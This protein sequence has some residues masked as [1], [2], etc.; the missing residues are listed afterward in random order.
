MHDDEAD[1]SQLCASRCELVASVVTVEQLPQHR[2]HEQLHW[3][4]PLEVEAVYLHHSLHNAVFVH[5]EAAL[6]GLHVLEEEAHAFHR[7]GLFFVV[8][9]EPRHQPGGEVGGSVRR[10]L[11]VGGVVRRWLVVG[12]GGRWWLVV[13]GGGMCK[14]V[15]GGV[16][17]CK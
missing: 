9:V 4:V 2:H 14:E 6:A 11:V 17:R 1:L 10:W 7:R 8:F 15:V 12:G 3:L 13:G 16:R 5:Q